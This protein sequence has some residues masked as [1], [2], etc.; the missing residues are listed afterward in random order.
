MVIEALEGR[1]PRLLIEQGKGDEFVDR[2]GEALTKFAEGFAP[3][4]DHLPDD[5]LPLATSSRDSRAATA[6]SPRSRTR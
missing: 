4:A 2:M 6:S 5:R 1:H 3:Q